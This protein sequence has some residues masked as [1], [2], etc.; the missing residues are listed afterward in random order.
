MIVRLICPVCADK[1]KNKL[2]SSAS[3]EVPVP[4]SRIVDDGRYEVRCEAGHKGTVFLDN[5]KF[6]LLFDM[7]LN[8]LID[9][10]PREAV[11]SF[12]S[13]LERF[14]EFYWRVV[15]KHLS[16]PSD[17]MAE[18]WKPVANQ[19]ERQLGMYI[20]AHL[21]LTRRKPILLNPNTDVRLRN[22]VIHKGYVPTHKEAV[23]FGDS[24]MN[25][26]NR[27]LDEL[28]N[29]AP[30]ALV[31]TYKEQ[32]PAPKNKSNKLTGIVNV[33]TAVD[34]RYPPKG[35]DSRVG[36][37]EAQFR[38]ILQDRQKRGMVVMSMEEFKRRF[39]EKA[40]EMKKRFPEIEVPR[41]TNDTR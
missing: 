23:S 18:A 41:K 40:A 19:S 38:R 24:V 9:G 14:Y 21:L 16:V 27:P 29:L 17:E 22:N 12:A 20:T 32:S 35:D 31:G 13:A 5:L 10:Y 26:I 36:G 39:P 11:S 33:L 37:V 2:L 15:M 4:V 25:L 6:E 7:G 30:E 28:R 8:A 3:I 1:V 34:V